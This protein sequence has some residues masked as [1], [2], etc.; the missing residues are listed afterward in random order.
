MEDIGVLYGHVIYFMAIWYILRPFGKLHSYL[1][2]FPRFGMLYHEKSGNP[3]LLCL[4]IHLRIEYL[5]TALCP[6]NRVRVARWFVFNPK[7]QF[8]VNFVGSCN[9]RCRYILWSLS[10]IYILAFY[11]LW[12][13]GV[14]RGNLV[15]FSCFGI[16]HQE[17]SGNP[18]IDIQHKYLCW[19]KKNLFLFPIFLF[20]AN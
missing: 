3:L 10:P 8:L 16:L 12:T 15:Y 18:V 5:H 9:G 14:V 11:I 19:H 2:H 1:V 7:I 20:C 4:Q 13:F 6:V 17:K